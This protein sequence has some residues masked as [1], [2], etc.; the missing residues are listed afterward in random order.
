MSRSDGNN[1]SWIRTATG[2]QLIING[3]IIADINGDGRLRIKQDIQT[4][5]PI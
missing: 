3:I 1:P 2:Y 4:N 5:E